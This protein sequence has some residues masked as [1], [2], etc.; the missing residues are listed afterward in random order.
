MRRMTKGVTATGRAGLWVRRTWADL[1]RGKGTRSN[2][3]KD[4]FST[5]AKSLFV[6]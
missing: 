6:T 1:D 3:R 5:E 2:F 4:F